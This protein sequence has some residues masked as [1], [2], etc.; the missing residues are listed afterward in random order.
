VWEEL[1]G[2]DLRWRPVLAMMGN[3][4]CHSGAAVAGDRVGGA[5]CGQWGVFRAPVGYEARIISKAM[6]QF[7]IIS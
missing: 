3:V 4:A 2:L 1:V 7:Q 6:P 5:V